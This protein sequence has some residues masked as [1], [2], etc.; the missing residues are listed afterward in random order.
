MEQ[1][2]KEER[3]LACAHIWTVGTKRR[4]RFKKCRQYIVIDCKNG[5]EFSA[6]SSLQEVRLIS[7]PFDLLWPITMWQNDLVQVLNLGP[8]R[9]Y[10]ICSLTGSPSTSM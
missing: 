3:A 8:K 4:Q 7:L 1:N 10:S 5:H 6:S 9:P 2:G